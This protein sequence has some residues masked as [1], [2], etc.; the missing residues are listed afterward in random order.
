MCENGHAIHLATLN[1]AW[2]FEWERGY[3]ERFGLVYNDFGSGL[4][5]RGPVKQADPLPS[6]Y[7]HLTGTQACVYYYA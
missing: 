1:L 4:D 2:Q 3:I 7:P 6:P 5:P